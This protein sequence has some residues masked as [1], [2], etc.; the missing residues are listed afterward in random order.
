MFALQN[1][2]VGELSLPG[3]QLRPA[4]RGGEERSHFDL[5]LSINES[6]DKLRCSLG[7]NTELFESETAQR[8]AR[9]YEQLLR[10]AMAAP[11]QPV[12]ELEMLSDGER[13][14]LVEWNSTGREY[15]GRGL[16][17]EQFEQRAAERGAEVA[18]SDGACVLGYA[19][20]DAAANRLAH[21]LLKRG[22]RPGERVGVLLERKVEAIIAM[23]AVW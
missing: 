13:E 6:V 16:A 17:H 10:E 8:M 20:L 18:L 4:G 21:L 14:Q 1:A 3:L 7:Y 11:E 9:H 23:L 2:P 5:A 15:D 22:L 12:G 19:E